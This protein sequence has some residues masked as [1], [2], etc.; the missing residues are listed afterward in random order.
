MERPRAHP[1][2]HETMSAPHVV[3]P[4]H[5][6]PAPRRPCTSG[7]DGEHV[8]MRRDR[9]GRALGARWRR[10]PT[11]P[12]RR[13]RLGAAARSAP[14]SPSR[15]ARSRQRARARAAA[16]PRPAAAGH[17]HRGPAHRRRLELWRSLALLGAGVAGQLLARRLA[18]PSRPSRKRE[19][20]RSYEELAAINQRH[21]HDQRGGRG[22][23]QAA[24]ASPPREHR[25]PAP[26]RPSSRVSARD[27]PPASPPRRDGRGASPAGA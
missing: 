10:W 20:E 27:P 6:G 16:Q 23:A 8:S 21:P 14:P 22:R 15:A 17:A 4:R 12:T 24:S 19:R 25:S 5:L 3:A 26:D 2:W 1:A 11:S 13:G 7:P 18:P 9:T